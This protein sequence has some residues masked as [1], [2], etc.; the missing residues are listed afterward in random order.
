MSQ[1][2]VNDS[3]AERQEKFESELKLMKMRVGTS[4]KNW[5]EDEC[6]I[7]DESCEH[8]VI[9]SGP[10]Y[11]PVISFPSKKAINYFLP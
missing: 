9:I 8:E 1:K 4:W 11:P 2:D 3:M 10:P 7:F 6:F 5:I